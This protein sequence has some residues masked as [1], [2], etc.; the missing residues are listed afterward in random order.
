MDYQ[1]NKSYVN[2]NSNFSMQ[3][4][5][6]P[7]VY[8]FDSANKTL[9]NVSN[10]FHESIDINIEKSFTD[11]NSKSLKEMISSSLPEN[12]L[13]SEETEE[14]VE[15]S[16]KTTVDSDE[17]YF[18]SEDEEDKIYGSSSDIYPTSSFYS[19]GASPSENHIELNG[20]KRKYQMPDKLTRK[21]ARNPDKWEKNVTKNAKNLGLEHTSVKTKKKVPARSMKNNC[22]PG[23]K[24]KCEQK[25]LEDRRKTIFQEFWSISE[26]SRKYDFILRN[27]QERLKVHNSEVNT[28]RKYSINYSFTDQSNNSISVCKTMFLN[29]LDISEQMVRTALKK[30]RDGQI[31]PTDLRGKSKPGTKAI[32]KEIT[33]SAVEH[34]NLFPRVESHYTRNDSQREYLEETLSMSKMYKMYVVWGKE[35]NKPLPNEGDSVHANIEKYS[36]KRNIYS[37]D[38]WIDDI[39]GA[40]QRGPKYEVT[41]VTY[42]MIYNFKNLSDNMN[43]KKSVQRRN[44]KSSVAV[45][46]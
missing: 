35:N 8:N 26:Y 43:W 4:H 25:L 19:T 12:L 6:D 1:A 41:R 28:R 10:V 23:C 32:K 45:P 16:D 22:G 44:T 17:V 15:C 42:D 39:K 36:S 34:I 9:E 29:T 37:Q 38:E 40:K 3:Q 2:L 33:D 31:N 14:V 21:K 27:V 7:V 13:P 11:E 24:L 30:I 5:Y 18:S 46:I 20:R